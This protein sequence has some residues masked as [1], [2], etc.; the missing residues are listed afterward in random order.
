MV[1]NYD[2]IAKTEIAKVTEAT[3]LTKAFAHT[4]VSYGLTSFHSYFLPLL[5]L[6]HSLEARVNS[7]EGQV[8]QL[9]MRVTEVEA[10]IDGK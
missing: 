2:D 8:E 6:A 5:S 4:Y 3:P 7:L 9:N 1:T 10:D